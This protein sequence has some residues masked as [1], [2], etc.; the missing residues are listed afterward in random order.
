[1]GGL[2][3]ESGAS[4]RCDRPC[5][6]AWWSVRGGLRRGSAR[7]GAR[8]GIFR[9]GRFITRGQAKAGAE[10]QPL[11]FA[12]GECLHH[13]LAR[14][15]FDAFAAHH[16]GVDSVAEVFDQVLGQDHSSGFFATL[17]EARMAATI[18]PFLVAS[19]RSMDSLAA[20]SRSCATVWS[21]RPS[22]EL[23]PL[24]ALISKWPEALAL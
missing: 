1:M 7:L 24:P 3:Q 5:P 12:L 18:S 13:A 6:R 15:E 11:R 22:P 16:D 9:L 20:S 17:P 23:S 4:L 19:P 21:S 2:P 14:L 10:L 8:V